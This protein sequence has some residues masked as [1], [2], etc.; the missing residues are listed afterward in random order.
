MK[1]LA[2]IAVLG[3]L[4]AEASA[5]SCIPHSYDID[6]L[7]PG[8]VQVRYHTGLPTPQ[9]PT[10]TQ[11]EFQALQSLRGRYLEAANVFFVS[12]DTAFVYGPFRADTSFRRHFQPESIL[13]SIAAVLK[14]SVRERSF[15]FRSGGGQCDWGSYSDIIG[16]RFLEFSAMPA[17]SLNALDDNLYLN[18]GNQPIEAYP[19]TGCDTAVGNWLEGDR[20][21]SRRFLGHS[22]PMAA[23]LEYFR[24][25][26]ATRPA[27]AR[28]AGTA[29]KHAGRGVFAWAARVFTLRGERR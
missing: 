10:S 25:G 27:E 21:H 4:V 15:W 19:T 16:R 11:S 23:V 28:P 13:V 17:D 26:V 5:C 8:L 2:L 24:T 18:P 3:V 12:I 20:L 7:A 29:P 1:P 6:T 14:G 22:F 9:G